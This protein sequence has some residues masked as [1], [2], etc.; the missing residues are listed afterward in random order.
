MCNIIYYDN[1][2]RLEGQLN[3]ITELHQHE[4]SLQP[5]M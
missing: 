1:I 5:A 3:D 2:Q 4:V